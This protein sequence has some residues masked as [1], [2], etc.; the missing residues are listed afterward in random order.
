MRKNQDKDANNAYDKALKTDS[1]KNESAK[2]KKTVDYPPELATFLGETLQGVRKTLGI[3]DGEEITKDQYRE[4]YKKMLADTDVKKMIHELKLDKIFNIE[5]D[6]SVP[7]LESVDEE[8]DIDDELTDDELFDID[9]SSLPM[10]TDGTRILADFML[11]CPVESIGAIKQKF[12][13][14]IDDEFIDN[15]VVIQLYIPYVAVYPLSELKADSDDETLRSFIMNEK[16]AYEIHPDTYKEL[17]KVLDRCNIIEGRKTI[18]EGEDV[19]G[20]IAEFFANGDVIEGDFSP[21]EDGYYE[22]LMEYWYCGKIY[23][24][25]DVIW[26]EMSNQTDSY[27]SMKGFSANLDM[28]N[29][30]YEACD[31]TKARSI[32]VDN[33]NHRVL[34]K[35]ELLDIY[36]HGK[37]KAFFEQLLPYEEVWV[38]AKKCAKEKTAPGYCIVCLNGK[39]YVPVESFFNP[40]TLESEDLIVAFNVINCT[41]LHHK[42]RG[43]IVAD[44][45]NVQIQTC[46]RFAKG[47][48]FD[49]RKRINQ[50]VETYRKYNPN[51]DLYGDPYD[52]PPFGSDDDMF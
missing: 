19:V 1:E 37:N 50:E 15:N 44:V 17:Q 27:G 4:F 18:K 46:V 20:Q 10:E 35:E 52:D 2:K 24:E 6:E 29:P 23:H 9:P 45:G 49:W 16:E 21:R 22:D 3:S 13:V 14:K 47:R 42:C 38:L 30:L 8:Q 41:P 11:D 28:F 39:F 12:P 26:T 25:K 43:M 40:E 51:F 48:N 5:P 7:T 34:P 32:V 36:T 31:I 33:N